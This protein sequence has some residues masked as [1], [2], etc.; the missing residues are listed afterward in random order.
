M[1]DTYQALTNMKRVHRAD[2]ADF[3]NDFNVN[4][5]ACDMGHDEQ[6]LDGDCD[7]FAGLT[8]KTEEEV[9]AEV[10]GDDLH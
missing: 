10:L 2:I 1:L 7:E 8:I 3:Q 6:L 4:L 9:L 5:H